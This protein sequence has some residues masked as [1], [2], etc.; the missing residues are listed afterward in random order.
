MNK[1]LNIFG[2]LLAI[3]WATTSCQEE[4]ESVVPGASS[5]LT[6]KT[7]T[8]E[9]GAPESTKGNLEVDV[10]P[11]TMTV[12]F[13]KKSTGSLAVKSPMTEGRRV[14]VS[15]ANLDEDCSVYVMGNLSEY[16]AGDEVP[17]PSNESG[18]ADFGINPIN[19]DMP[20]AA[21]DTWVYG[22]PGLKIEEELIN[23]FL[24]QVTIKSEK[25]DDRTIKSIKVTGVPS[26]IYPFGSASSGDET[27]DEATASDIALAQGSDPITLYVPK[28]SSS[29]KII[30]TVERKDGSGITKHETYT[31][32]LSE[33]E[34]G[35]S[36][37]EKPVSMSLEGVSDPTT[38]LTVD[39]VNEDTRYIRFGVSGQLSMN[40]T[41]G[42]KE[43]TIVLQSGASNGETGWSYNLTWPGIN[44]AGKIEICS[45][46][47]NVLW[48]KPLSGGWSQP[49]V[50]GTAYIVKI[51]AANY[52][53]STEKS[54]KL[55]VP[56][57]KPVV[58]GQSDE[59]LTVNFI[60]DETRYVTFGTTTLE[61]VY[62]DGNEYTTT[63][64]A[65]AANGA[66]NWSYDLSWDGNASVTGAKM[67]VYNG[68]TA[69]AT[70]KSLTSSGYVTLQ[71]GVTYTLKISSSYAGSALQTIKLSTLGSTCTTRHI[72]KLTQI[73]VPWSDMNG[74]RDILGS[75]SFEPYQSKSP[76]I[77]EY[78][79]GSQ[80]Y[81]LIDAQWG[82]PNA[83]S[84]YARPGYSY[85]LDGSDP[86]YKVY[87][88]DTQYIKA[89]GYNLVSKMVSYDALINGATDMSGTEYIP[90]KKT[91]F[92]LNHRK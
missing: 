43:N 9:F 71:P 39:I 57:I 64:T 59:G 54:A 17:W 6:D 29:N 3:A 85:I 31:K 67:S 23:T 32:T 13:Y 72:G 65:K 15:A 74:V 48:T 30:T 76:K 63:V 82:W 58:Y 70:N 88:S 73:Y 68:T 46:P 87:Y 47:T 69:V 91:S 45:S 51:V 16:S 1:V 92:T 27:G 36:T 26:K 18:L 20:R 66:T 34:A 2:S 28:L 77:R 61:P 90:A 10:T 42:G 21:T 60:N 8:V 41:T 84:F 53:G 33:E 12:A 62:G 38:G 11:K 19:T 5:S 55:I 81:T 24:Q 35:S 50:G 83:V 40:A 4:I 52:T 78:K 89:S 49:L 75:K 25:S 79:D 86:S 22:T 44:I 56:G 14:T 37:N 80:S 7:V